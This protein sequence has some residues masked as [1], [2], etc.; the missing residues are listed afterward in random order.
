VRGVDTFGAE[1]P[2]SAAKRPLVTILLAHPSPSLCEAITETGAGNC[3]R[4]PVQ[5]GVSFSSMP[6]EKRRN[7]KRRKPF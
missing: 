6:D 1:R 2:S 4:H 7:E 3:L 5:R